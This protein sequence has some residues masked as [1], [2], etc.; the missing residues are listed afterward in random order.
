M[1]KEWWSFAQKEDCVWV[2]Y[3]LSIE[4]CIST[5]KWQGVKAEIKCMIDQVLVKRDMLRYVQSVLVV[6]GM[7]QGLSDSHVVPCK[8][9][10][11]GAWIKRRELVFGVRMIKIEKLSEHQ[12]RE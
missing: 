1:V 8:V 11:V 10:L 4:V 2:A 3:I 5:Q 12:Y 9:R 6:R 7:G